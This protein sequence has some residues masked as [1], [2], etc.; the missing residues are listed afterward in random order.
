MTIRKRFLLALSMVAAT[1]TS[2]QIYA[3]DATPQYGGQL[4]Y[5]QAGAK[6]SLFPGR[7]TDASAQDVWLNACENL[8]NL[9]KENNIVPALAESWQVLDGGR[10][11][12]FKLRQGVQ[13]SDGTPF[14]AN[15]VAFV[16]NEAKA[17]NFIYMSL[18]GGIRNAEAV[19]Q[20]TVAFHFDQPAAALIHDLTYRCMCIFSPTAYKKLGESGMATRIVGTGPFIETKYVKGEYI[21]FRR[22]PNYWRKGLPYLDSLKIVIVPDR[23]TRTVML[24]G[25]EIDRTV[26]ISD[27][28]I[29]QLKANKD[30]RVRTVTS[31]LQ[32]YVVLNN[33]VKPL[34]NVKVRQALNYAIDRAGI[35]QAV[36]AGSGAIL[37]EAPI[38]TKGV[39][40]FADMRENG[41]DSIYA[42]DPVRAR[43][44]LKEAGYEDRDGDGQVESPDGQ[45]LTFNLL[46]QKG[47]VNG[48]YQIAQ[49]V[50]IFLGE[51][52]I[53]V[54]LEVLESATFSTAVSQP[55][56]KAMYQ[57]ALLSWTIPTADPDEPMMYFMNSRAWKP[58]GANR[59]FFKSAEVDRLADLAHQEMDPAER[60]KD[61]YR[62]MAQI[63]KDA[64]I[65]FLPTARITLA[66]RTYVHGD[67]ILP[68]GN[69]PASFSWIDK[70][71]KKRQKVDH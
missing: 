40:G 14:D 53:N 68:V 17:K 9:D 43:R 20:Y 44:L 6:F 7:N 49:L 13:F 30:I 21:L 70:K 47:A 28:D 5:A 41:K 29:P 71:E 27:F 61:I 63:M 31:T 46:T 51:I 60:K 66:T 67:S 32:F 36:F 23:A 8:V 45:P 55:P 19:G 35:V 4:I 15:A 11:F 69:Y 34:D 33:L 48:D 64:P 42:Y 39:F 58:V 26:Q 56:D 38:L 16:F 50:Q 10:T 2:V 24:Q 65:I 12:T 25:G 3:Q 52:G 1:V 22:N 54:H 37:P 62:W 59:M 57:L 18:L